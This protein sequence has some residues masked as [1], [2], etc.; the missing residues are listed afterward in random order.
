MLGAVSAG[1]KRRVA[2]GGTI[3]PEKPSHDLWPRDRQSLAFRGVAPHAIVN[4]ESIGMRRR[5]LTDGETAI[6]AI[7]Q[8]GYGMHNSADKVFISPADEAILFVR[9]ENGMSKVMAN[10]SNLAARRANGTIP[11]DEELRVKWLRLAK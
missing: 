5:D 6:L 10:L 8:L 4:K 2:A 11:S 7:I 3:L 9:L 1:V